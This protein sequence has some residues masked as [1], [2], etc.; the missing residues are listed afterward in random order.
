SVSA[1]GFN[2]NEICDFVEMTRHKPIDVR[3]IEYMPFSGN[4]W[5][6]EKMVSYRDML[7]IIKNKFDNFVD[8]PNAPNDTSKA[9]A[10]PGFAGQVGFITSMTEHFC[11]SCN[12]LRITADG[13]L[14]VCLFGNTEV[15]LRDALRSNCSEDDLTALISA[16]VKRKKKQHAGTNNSGTSFFKNIPIMNTKHAVFSSNLPFPQMLSR[17]MSTSSKFTHVDKY[18]KAHMVDV[19]GKS[20]TSRTAVA[21]ASVYV[22]RKI[23]EL[24]HANSIAKGDVLSVSQIA[25]IMAAKRTSDI[26]PLC[27]NIPLSSVNVKTELDLENSTVNIQSIVQCE[28]KTGVEMEALLCCTTAALTVYDMCKALSQDIVI[29]DVMLL[30]KVGGR[31]T[32]NRLGD[33]IE[34]PIILKKYETKPIAPIETF[35][36]SHI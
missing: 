24:I 3:F 26:I 25:G 19:S 16:A 34:E 20:I 13:N 33:K 5:E 35:V 22:G 36:P 9:W 30:H 32:Y 23:A 29:G 21:R 18:G 14:K 4:K 11:G 8:L 1:S 12:R 7:S 17:T 31:T 15:S 28:G 27:H 6:T 2:D 10:V